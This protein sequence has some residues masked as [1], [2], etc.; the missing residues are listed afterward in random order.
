VWTLNGRKDIPFT[1]PSRFEDIFRRVK[2]FDALAVSIKRGR[3][4]ASLSVTLEDEARHGTL[5]AGVSV[6]NKSEV[7]VVDAAGRSLR[8]VTVAQN[9][10]EETSRKT[11]KRLE[12]RLAIRKADGLETRS[13]RRALKRLGRRRHMRT[14]TFSHAAASKLVKWV[15]PGTILVLEDLRPPPP[16]RRGQR[17]DVR[18]HFY[19]SL[20]RRIEEKAEAAAIPVHYISVAGNGTRCS[21]CGAAGKAVRHLFYCQ[22]CGNESPL[23]K[24]A[25]VNVRNKFTVTRPW[26]AVNQS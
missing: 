20:R 14:K 3:L 8:V 1:I 11:R 26:A 17:V 13:V 24:N 12:R 22:A 5:P 15:G 23:S 16:S 18:P 4:V 25:A 2:S 9:V 7:A 21:T 19:E 10:M 6:S